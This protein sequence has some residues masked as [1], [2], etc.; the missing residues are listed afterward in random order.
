M[1]KK[2]FIQFAAKIKSAHVFTH[3][4]SICEAEAKER[5]WAMAN[6]VCDVA[7]QDNPRFDENRFL[8]ACGLK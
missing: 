8:A 5:A 6:M 4:H 7:K 3:S 2:H 1:T